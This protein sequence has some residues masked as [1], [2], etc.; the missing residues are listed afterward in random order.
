[1]NP[2]YV[3]PY[4][5]QQQWQPVQQLPQNQVETK[6]IAYFVDTAEQLSTINPMP[7]V[8]YLG[9]NTKDSKIFMRR[10][11]NDGLMELKTYSVVG[12]H[13]KKTDT[14]E[15]LGRLAKIE[16]KLGVN[17]G[18]NIIDVTE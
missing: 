17:N 6:V 1:M 12:E 14:Q 8:I 10:M 5:Q 15:I 13:T 7:N 4:M 3:P 11:N 2:Y 9:I 16:K 18:R